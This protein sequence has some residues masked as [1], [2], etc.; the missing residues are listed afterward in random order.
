MLTNRNTNTPEG[1]SVYSPL[2]VGE[3]WGWQVLNCVGVERAAMGISRFMTLVRKLTNQSCFSFCSYNVN[4]A[5][6]CPSCNHSRPTN[7][8]GSGFV[9]LYFSHSSSLFLSVLVSPSLSLSLCWS[10]LSSYRTNMPFLFL[11]RQQKHIH[12]HCHTWGEVFSPIGKTGMQYHFLAVANI[13]H[14]THSILFLTWITLWSLTWHPSVACL[15]WVFP[16]VSPYGLFSQQCKAIRP[17]K[18]T[19]SLFS[20]SWKK[21]VIFIQKSV[22]RSGCQSKCFPK[23]GADLKKHR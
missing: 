5:P 8:T 23:M 7:C 15:V 20:T 19:C 18:L 10:H 3:G 6:L 1:P 17:F 22:L 14:E 9:S 4:G 21:V 12:Y 13:P 16:F 11:T 2:W